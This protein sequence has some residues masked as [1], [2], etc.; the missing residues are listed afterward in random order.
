[1]DHQIFLYVLCMANHQKI[2]KKFKNVGGTLTHFCRGPK[3]CIGQWDPYIQNS[4]VY[5]YNF[6]C[7]FDIA[8][9]QELCPKKFCTNLACLTYF[10]K[11]Y[12]LYKTMNICYHSIWSCSAKRHWKANPTATGDRHFE[13]L[14]KLWSNQIGFSHT[15]PMTSQALHCICDQ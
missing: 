12:Q 3:I 15:L 13:L 11:L 14:G 6:T 8:I 10:P 1:M 7:N 9:M 4:C 5:R 2:D